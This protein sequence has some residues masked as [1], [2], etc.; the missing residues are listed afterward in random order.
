MR[1]CARLCSYRVWWFVRHIQWHTRE[2]QRGEEELGRMGQ[3]VSARK[4]DG[5]QGSVLTQRKERMAGVAL[6]GSESCHIPLSFIPP[7]RGC[8]EVSRQNRR[9]VSREAP[10]N[11]DR[12]STYCISA[13][14]SKCPGSQW[15]STPRSVECFQDLGPVGFL[16]KEKLT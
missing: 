6:M 11:C 10:Q 16:N 4:M 5:P 13:A 3:A 7:F 8:P 15:G 12:G 9:T 1:A 2:A 14:V